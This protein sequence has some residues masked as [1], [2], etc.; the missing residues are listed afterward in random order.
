VRAASEV[1][2]ERTSTLISTGPYAFSRNPMYIGWTLLYLGAALVTRNAWM[3]ASL[4]IVVSLVH[5]EVL[6]EE[7]ILE[8]AFGEE[9]LRYQKLVRRYL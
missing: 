5:L 7:Q 9:Y 4:P 2:L 1:A 6:R 8:Q 3:V